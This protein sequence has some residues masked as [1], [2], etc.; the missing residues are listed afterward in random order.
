[1]VLID[2]IVSNY[3]YRSLLVCAMFPIA[4]WLRVGAIDSIHPVRLILKYDRLLSEILMQ[5]KKCC[6]EFWPKGRKIVYRLSVRVS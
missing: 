4:K 1:M 5:N 6:H 2:R 3:Q